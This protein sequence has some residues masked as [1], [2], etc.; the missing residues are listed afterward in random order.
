MGADLRQRLDLCGVHL[1][2]HD[3]RAGFVFGQHQ[4]SE[5]T[6]RARAQHANVSGNLVEAGCH[7]AQSA[8]HF[9]QC[10]MGRERF[11]FVGCC[12]ER[13]TC[14]FGHMCG[15]CFPPTFWRVQAGADSGATLGQ[16]IDRGQGGFDPTNTHRN[17][18]GVAREF[19]AQCQ[20]CCIHRMG[21]AD[22]DDVIKFALLLL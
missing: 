16:F 5:A 13:Q 15:D 22:L 3:G 7:C 14:D 9:D 10:V 19:L 1:A 11:E 17:L 21:A 18:V 12:D 6:T 8:R 20:R 2:W 4:L